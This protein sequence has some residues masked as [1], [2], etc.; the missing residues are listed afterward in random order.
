[1]RFFKSCVSYT[2]FVYRLY[3]VQKIQAFHHLDREKKREPE[4]ADVPGFSARTEISF[5]ELCAVPLVIDSAHSG[6]LKSKY[7]VQRQFDALSLC[8]TSVVA[9]VCAKRAGSPSGKSW[10]CAIQLYAAGKRVR[11][12]SAPRCSYGGL[13]CRVPLLVKVGT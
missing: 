4:K 12:S 10:K 8:H 13:A 6:N 3:R 2:A 5:R 7:T 1:M 11:C 9:L